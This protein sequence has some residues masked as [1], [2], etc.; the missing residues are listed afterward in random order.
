MTT[1]LYDT[2]KSSLEAINCQVKTI[3]TIDSN[4]VFIKAVYKQYYV[5]FLILVPADKK[6]HTFEESIILTSDNETFKN[7][8]QAKFINSCSVKNIACESE[9]N[10]LYMNINY[11]KNV[12]LPIVAMD[13][14]DSHENVENIE[15]DKDS[16]LL[17]YPVE[18]IINVYNYTNILPKTIVEDYNKLIEMR[19]KYFESQVT[20]LLDQVELKKQ[21]IKNHF[22]KC[23]SKIYNIHQDILKTSELL[24]DV[25][26]LQGKSSNTNDRTRFKIE[27]LII[28]Y[29]NTLDKLNAELIKYTATNFNKIDAL[30]Q[31]LIDLDAE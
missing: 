23:N 17:I 19:D 24:Q 9:Y 11:T 26:I 15:S 12:T 21:G 4:I 28:E 8:N 22:Y 1:K 27:R 3:Y 18:T 30:T 25:Y 20:Q 6:M 13:G 31:T 16:N 5:P 14:V 7:F 2:L 29:I 10:L